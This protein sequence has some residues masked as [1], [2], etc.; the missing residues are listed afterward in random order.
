M[1]VNYEVLTRRRMSKRAWME[2]IKAAERKWQRDPRDTIARL[3]EERLEKKS[4]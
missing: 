3:E 1:A 2:S 4:L